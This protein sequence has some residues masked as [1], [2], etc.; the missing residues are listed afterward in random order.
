MSYAAV[1]AAGVPGSTTRER[2]SVALVASRVHRSQSLLFSFKFYKMAAAGGAGGVGSINLRPN[3]P[4]AFDGTRDFLVVNTWVYKV[5]QYLALAQLANPTAPMTDANRI[6]YASTFL[7]GTAAVWWYTVVQTALLPNTWEDFKK[8]VI[9]E[10]VPEDHVRRARDKLR[11]LKQVTSVSKYI[12]EF[13]NIVLTIPDVTDGEKW[14]KFCA[15]LKTEIRIE[16]MKSTASTF[17][18]AAK[19]ALRVDSALFAA[20][21]MEA[22]GSVG[23][24]PS[25]EAPTPM[26]I[27]NM[28]TGRGGWRRYET[29]QRE[30]DRRNNACFKCHK[31][32]CRP[33]KH[34][35]RSRGPGA[36][37]VGVRAGRQ[38][39]LDNDLDIDEQE[40]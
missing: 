1:P 17:E 12:S 2:P 8:A 6:M 32:G 29:T 19:I 30:E 20:G 37:N 21:R 22:R 26:E 28:E 9:A 34:D 10:F 31:P 23:A 4:D 3:K 24:S 38:A 13:R 35:K 7:T 14:D 36:N 27:G 18:E 16:V 40:N 5:E 39:E 15:G 33:W 25:K 11:K